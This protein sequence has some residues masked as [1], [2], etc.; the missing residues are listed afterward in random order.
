MTTT[1]REQRGLAI[2]ATC[3]INKS[4]ESYLVPSQSG[5]GKYT[6]NVGDQPHCSCPDHETTGSSCKHIFAVKYFIQREL[7]FDGS[8]TVTEAVQV[9]AVRKT[10]Y[11]QQWPAYNAAQTNEK[12]EF[13]ILLRDLCNQV[14]E[15]GMPA[16]GRPRIPLSDAIL[17]ACFK[18]YST[19]SGRRFMCDL[20]DAQREG[21]IERTPHFN[22]V[23]N[24]L[25]NEALTPIS[26]RLPVTGRPLT[27]RF[28]Q[29]RLVPVEGSLQRRSTFSATNGKSSWRTTT[30]GRTSNRRLA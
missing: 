6:V 22:S 12:R 17:M 19:I 18:V 9:T 26:K 5:N 21:F 14:K 3:K 8:V 10:T 24:A 27:L 4:G 1:T 23:F 20:D 25:D 29:E 13:L 11:K 15:P 2:A 16:R 30:S 7:N 28:G